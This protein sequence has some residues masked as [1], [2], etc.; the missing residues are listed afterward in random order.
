MTSPASPTTAI[1]NW[2][3]VLDRMAAAIADA[4]AGIEDPDA[5]FD[6]SPTIPA[7]SL[8]I[9]DEQLHGFDERL[10]AVCTL[11]RQVEDALA[12]DEAMIQ[13]FRKTAAEARSRPVPTGRL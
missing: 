3:A 1:D 7:D 13:A 10:A 8:R 6:A 12:E 2:L 4:A 9:V 5:E 11:A